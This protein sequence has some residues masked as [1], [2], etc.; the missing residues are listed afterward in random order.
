MRKPVLIPAGAVVFIAAAVAVWWMLRRPARNELRA[1]GT[2]EARNVLVGSRVAGRVKRV[3]VREGDRVAAG[4]LLVELENT[5]LEPELEQSRARLRHTREALAMMRRGYRVE[6]VT[7]ARDSAREAQ[8]QLDAAVHGYRPEEIAQ[9]RADRDRAAADAKI[10]EDSLARLEPLIHKDEISRQQYDDAVAR[11]DSAKASLRRAESV[12]E[13]M[14]NGSR[15][16]DIAA[17]RARHAAAEANLRRMEAGYRPE[18]VAQAEADVKQA[19][20]EVAESEA[21]LK[22]MQV[23]APAAAVVEVLDLR[24]GDLVAANT[25][26]VTLLETGQL[27]IR[28]YIPET[29]LSKIQLGQSAKLFIDSA[30]GEAFPA[31]VEQINQQAEFLPRNVQTLDERVHQ[32]FGV[33]LRMDNGAGRLRPGMAADVTFPLP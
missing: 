26:L 10:A 13:Q 14:R 16:E 12:Y 22:E 21:R 11:R 27:Y 24:P 31:T 19:E 28:V 32:V 25:P 30:P 5:D 18:E 3:L 9:A 7:A 17:A 29:Q 15:P 23:T 2:I 20:G 33:R 1:S 6:D 4:Q 8:A